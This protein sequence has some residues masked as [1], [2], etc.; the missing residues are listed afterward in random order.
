MPDLDIEQL[1]ADLSFREGAAAGIAASPLE[2]NLALRF[3]DNL[4]RVALESMDRAAAAG[5][6]PTVFVLS[7]RTARLDAR[8]VDG[9]AS[10]IT[11]IN[12]RT[13]TD[14]EGKLIFTA[15]H[16]TGGWAIPLP[17]GSVDAALDLLEEKGFGHLPIAIVYPQTRALSC[18]EEG[19]MSEAPPM[20]LDLPVHS[21]PVTIKDI[22]DVLEDVRRNSLLTPQIGP[23][24]F[25]AD[26]AGYE[27]GAEAE[28]QIQWIVAAQLRSNFRPLMID[29]EQITPLGRIDIVMTDPAPADGNPL[30]P[31][32][33]ELKALKSKSHGGAAFAESKNVKAILK[34]MRQAK[35]YREVKDAQYSVLGCYDMRNNKTDILSV[36]LCV[37]ARARYFQDDRVDAFVFPVYGTSDDAQEEF[38]A[39]ATG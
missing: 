34:G 37:M 8:A 6:A 11:D 2:D 18:Y 9:A 29:T 10:R 21:K 14:W 39:A 27:P 7:D 23:P 28:R 22:F 20:N 1:V 25:W 12:L 4:R 16:G 3:F 38:A 5:A 17:G 15:P 33:I 24:G 13:P 26:A 35:S 32:I 36:Q 19:G 31:A 30:H